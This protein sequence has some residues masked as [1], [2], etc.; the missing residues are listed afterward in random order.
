M[1]DVVKKCVN[2]D[3]GEFGEMLGWIVKRRERERDY[4]VIYYISIV[5]W[6][7]ILIIDLNFFV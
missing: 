2:E 5:D 7:V 1:I 6:L 4:Y 3:E